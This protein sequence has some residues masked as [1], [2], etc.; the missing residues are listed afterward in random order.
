VSETETMTQIWTRH[1]ETLTEEKRA[2]FLL[3]LKLMKF[4]GNA[5]ADEAFDRLLLRWAI[6]K[7]VA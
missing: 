6:E 3:T 2:L 1:Y 4:Q 7:P 5:D